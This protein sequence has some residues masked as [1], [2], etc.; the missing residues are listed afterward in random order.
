M[1]SSRPIIIRIATAADVSAMVAIRTNERGDETLW[2][3]RIA[4]YLSCEYS[5]QQA[6]PE[7]AVFVAIDED[8]LVGFVAAHRTRRLNCDCELQ[9]INVAEERRGQGIAD[10]LMTRIL[11]WFHHQAAK[12]ICVNVAP[13]NTAAR[14]VYARHGAQ[15]LNE[16]WMIWDDASPL[17]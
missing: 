15:P 3:H 13:E 9:W 7:R 8:E 16:H 6:L 5:P 10:Q 2:T 17:S 12:R 11:E 1:R 14:R 4:G